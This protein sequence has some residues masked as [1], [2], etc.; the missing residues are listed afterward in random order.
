MDT[1]RE[2]IGIGRYIPLILT[3]CDYIILN[4]SWLIAVALMDQTF[5]EGSGNMWLII[6][7]AF[8]FPC[9]QYCRQQSN[10]TILTDRLM[11]S[12]LYCVVTE[13]V[14]VMAILYIVNVQVIFEVIFV[15]SL[16]LLLTLSSVSLIFKHILYALRRKGYNYRKAIIIGSGKTARDLLEQL[17]SDPG[18][19]IRIA[20]IFDD[21]TTCDNII[22]DIYQDEIRSINLAAEFAADNE[23]NIIYFALDQYD[24]ELL[25]KMMQL[26]EETGSTF[27]YIVKLPKILSPQFSVS[28]I[29][30]IPAFNHTFSPLFYLHNKFLKRT[31][32]LAI[33]IPFTLVCPIIFIPIAIG[34]KLSSP[35]PVFFKQKRTGLYGRAFICLKFRTMKVNAESDKVQTSRHDTRKTKFGDFLRKTSLD[36]LPQFINVLFGDMSVV[37]PRPHMESQTEEYRRLIGKY[38]IRHAVKPGITGLAQVKGFRGPT[39]QLWRMEKRVEYDMKYISNWNIFLD[40]RIIFMTVFNQIKGEENAF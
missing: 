40:I 21:R 8:I 4:I 38:M 7:I 17:Q 18:Y 16:S 5:G 27:T 15:F 1:H 35:G 20:G 12:V 19:G 26:S 33:S 30:D 34:I 25:A 10:R 13:V 14:I 23:I 37:G 29:G 28:K 22:N 31:L 2:K 24:S 39:E 32:D 9:L 3:L 6:N 36:E 11:A